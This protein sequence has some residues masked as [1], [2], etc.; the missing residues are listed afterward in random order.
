V[1]EAALLP[2]TVIEGLRRSIE[3]RLSRTE[4]RLLAAS[5]RRDAQHQHDIAIVGAALY[6]LGKRQER[7]LNFVPMLTRGGPDL[8]D[9]MRTA[10]G[11]QM[12]GVLTAAAASTR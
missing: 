5:K 12:R 3:H 1:R 11:V 6:P 4:R 2:P 8:V 9:E 7:V 10:A